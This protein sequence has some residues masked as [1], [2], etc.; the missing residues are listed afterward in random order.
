MDANGA[1]Y[2]EEETLGGLGYSTLACFPLITG[3][4]VLGTL[5]IA[6]IP[7]CGLLCECTRTA[8]KVARLIGIA[9]H[10]SFLVEEVRRLNRELD[11]ENAYLKRRIRHETPRAG[12]VAESPVMRE[13]LGRADQV[14]SSETTVLIRG[15][16]G[17]GKEGLARRIHEASPRAEGPFVVVNVGAIPEGL[18]ESELFGHERGAFTGATHRRIGSFEQADGGTLFLDEIGDAPQPVQVKLLRALQDRE[19]QRVGGR[20]TRRVDVRVVAATHQ[21]LEQMIDEGS[22]RPDLYYRLNI[23]PIVLPP[24]RERRDD[25]RLLARHLVARHA[26]RMGRRPPQIPESAMVALEAHIWLGNVRELENFLERAMIFSPG[27][28]LVLP[29]APGTGD[30]RRPGHSPTGQSG[31][32]EVPDVER[33]EESV[34]GLL[35]RSLD[36]TGGKIYGPDGAAERLGLKPTTLQGKLRRY[37]IRVERRTVRDP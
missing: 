24:L 20:G 13:I 6:H 1:R 2:A 36:A 34:R 30:T 27:E 15:E 23:Y 5:D 12:Y 25:I 8:E 14:G 9:L 4:R 16:T 22:F 3:D 33:F 17:T 32:G 35:C 11:R 18:I 37:G 19:V 10:N 7:R 28:T 26:A 29:E 21:P 31:S